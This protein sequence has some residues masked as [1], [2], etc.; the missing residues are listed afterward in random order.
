MA[1][2]VDHSHSF[3]IKI[4]ARY[5]SR[6]SKITSHN[7]NEIQY[8]QF[9]YD[10][11]NIYYK[12]LPNKILLVSNDEDLFKYVIEHQNKYI[13]TR[14]LFHIKPDVANAIM[15]NNWKSDQEIIESWM[16]EQGFNYP[17]I[18]SIT[19]EKTMAIKIRDIFID[20]EK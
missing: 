13:S 15:F 14:S 19:N 7:D 4:L 1:L 9:K 2:W 11:F 17:T 20:D 16:D 6:K 12:Y 8:F 3:G 10:D 5:L 18:T